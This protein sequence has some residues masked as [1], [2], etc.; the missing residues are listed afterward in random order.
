LEILADH[1]DIH[2][3]QLFRRFLTADVSVIDQTIACLRGLASVGESQDCASIKGLFAVN[4]S[5][6]KA[7]AARAL[8]ALT[9]DKRDALRDLVAERSHSVIWV[10][11]AACLRERING[12]WDIFK[13]LLT[14][15]NDA[16][17]RLVCH[18]A[19]ATLKKGEILAV[20][21]DYVKQRY[22]YNVVVLF[23]RALYAPPN[24]R[25]HLDQL[26]M[27][28]FRKLSQEATGNWAGLTL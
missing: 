1:A 22:Y 9:S 5:V 8:L 13:P 25:K 21:T 12:D 27:S 10:A 11:V 26:E 4:S 7:A 24:V 18:F 2:D 16:I 28:H 6:I 14:D 15:E 3:R 17:R 23:D 19:I 20:L